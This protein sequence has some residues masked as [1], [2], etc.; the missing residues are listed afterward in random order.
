MIASNKTMQLGTRYENS[1]ADASHQ[2][3]LVGYQVIQRPLTDRE[4]FSCLLAPNKQLV[5]G[6]QPNSRWALLRWENLTVHFLIS[7][8]FMIGGIST[9]GFE[10]DKFSVN[11]K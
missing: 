10:N 6:R 9:D 2:D 8:E 7:R 4:E 3:L 5:I 11:G 1:C